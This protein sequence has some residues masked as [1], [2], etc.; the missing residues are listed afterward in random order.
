MRAVGGK[1]TK[2]L[3]KAVGPNKSWV[4]HENIKSTVRIEVNSFSKSLEITENNTKRIIKIHSPDQ[5]LWQIENLIFQ[6]FLSLFLQSY[7]KA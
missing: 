6:I 1:Y 4:F 3:V 5:K 2:F 7:L